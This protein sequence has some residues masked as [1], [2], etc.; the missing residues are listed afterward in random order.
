MNFHQGNASCFL[1]LHVINSKIRIVICSVCAFCFFTLQTP[2]ACDLFSLNQVR[3]GMGRFL[4]E[5]IL[6][7][8]L[9]YEEQ[10][11]YV[12]SLLAN[13]SVVVCTLYKGTCY[14]GVM[15]IPVDLISGSCYGKQ[16][17]F[18]G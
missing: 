6:R 9:D 7:N 5:I 11:T 10:T 17:E 12:M 15:L 16:N 8:S 1:Q 3:L 13:V 2:V 4:Q 18:N 14:F